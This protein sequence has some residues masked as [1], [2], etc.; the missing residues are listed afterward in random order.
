MIYY[1]GVAKNKYVLADYTVF[2]GE[3]RAKFQQ[4]ANS[5]IPD[6]AIKATKGDSYTCYMKSNSD[7]YSFGCMVSPLISSDIPNAF[8]EKLQE[9]AYRH[10][11]YGTDGDTGSTSR[12]L[13]KLIKEV[14]VMLCTKYRMIRRKIA[15]I[16]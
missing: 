9:K 6:G 8:I 14:I 7:G 16:R 11:D 13:T 3:F 10:L 1:G 12:N 4:I 15:W 5:S 2:D